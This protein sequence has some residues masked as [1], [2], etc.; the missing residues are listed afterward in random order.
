ML[1]SLSNLF[2]SIS[3]LRKIQAIASSGGCDL[4]F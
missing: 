4:Q 1:K 2:S 3:S